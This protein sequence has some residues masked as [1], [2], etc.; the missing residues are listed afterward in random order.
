[1]V[2]SLQGFG[3]IENI[4]FQSITTSSNLTSKLTMYIH[5]SPGNAYHFNFRQEPLIWSSK[6]TLKWTSCWHSSFQ[7]SK[8]LTVKKAQPSFT[9]KHRY[10]MRLSVERKKW[11][12][13]Y[14]N[15][16]KKFCKKD[17]WHM[18]KSLTNL[19]NWCTWQMRKWKRFGS[20]RWKKSIAKLAL[21]SKWSDY[22]R[23]LV[24]R[25]TR[26]ERLWVS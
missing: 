12:K 7:P 25:H 5:F 6:M 10:S 16:G 24:T 2:D 17:H 15:R 8:Q 3:C 4:W 13:E 21:S 22:D 1:M 19:W 20:K 26:R 18:M 14:S 11:I 23:K 9:T